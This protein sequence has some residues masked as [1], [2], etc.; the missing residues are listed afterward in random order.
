MAE[1]VQCTEENFGNE[2][3]LMWIKCIE[4]LETTTF[5]DFLG[6]SLEPLVCAPCSKETFTNYAIKHVATCKKPHQIYG[7]GFLCEETEETLAAVKTEQFKKLCLVWR[8][9]M[10]GYTGDNLYEHAF[11][12]GYTYDKL[13]ELVQR[14]GYQ[15]LEGDDR[16]QITTQLLFDYKRR[17]TLKVPGRRK[18]FRVN[19]S[20]PKKH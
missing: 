9:K 4:N 12:V 19:K 3:Y 14:L 20:K 13:V 2:S 10:V 11:D 1:K 17:P 18:V 7:C 6:K 8:M 15:V 5:M 16:P